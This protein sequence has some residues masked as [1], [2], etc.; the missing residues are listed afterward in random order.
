M[1]DDQKRIISQIYIA[2]DRLGASI[3]L[4]C[5]IGSFGDTLDDSEVLEMMHQYNKDGSYINEIICSID[6]TPEIRRNRI[7]LVE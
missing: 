7:K 3:E 1:T 6:D 4:L 5:L 2:V